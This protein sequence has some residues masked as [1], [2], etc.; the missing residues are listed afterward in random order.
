[1]YYFYN[2][3]KIF[4]FLNFQRYQ[5]KC[6]FNG[7]FCFAECRRFI[8]SW[9]CFDSDPA[10]EIQTGLANLRVGLMRWKAAL[11]IYVNKRRAKKDIDLLE[12]GRHSSI[13][14]GIRRFNVFRMRKVAKND[15]KSIYSQCSSSPTASSLRKA[16]KYVTFDYSSYH[17]VTSPS[18]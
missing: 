2:I 1:M 12:N 14:P 4:K 5:I 18:Y 16:G 8:D 9:E 3:F 11:A 7:I 15:Q 6:T 17:Y 13:N 10:R